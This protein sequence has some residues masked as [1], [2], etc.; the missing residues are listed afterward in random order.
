MKNS[1][2]LA[3]KG[4]ILITALAMTACT[5]VKTNQVKTNQI[6]ISYVPPKNPAHQQVYELLKGRQSLEKLKEFLSPFRLEW[7]LNVS[8][9]ECDG[10]ADAMY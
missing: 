3:G 8:L 6:R 5:A 4:M 1:L 7:V 9:T 2:A 10:E